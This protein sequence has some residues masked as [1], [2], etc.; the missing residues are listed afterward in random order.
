MIIEMRFTQI[1]DIV[2]GKILEWK[3]KQQDEVTKG[4]ALVEIDVG[5]VNEEFEAPATGILTE[6]RAA[7]GSTV[8][9]GDIIA[10]ITTPD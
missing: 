9:A 10:I 3:K 6:I 4:E 2:E 5:K 8:Y 1:G 7:E